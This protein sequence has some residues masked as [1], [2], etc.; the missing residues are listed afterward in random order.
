[1]RCGDEA[2]LIANRALVNSTDRQGE[3]N[4]RDFECSI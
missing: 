2:C 4:E 3:R 1:M